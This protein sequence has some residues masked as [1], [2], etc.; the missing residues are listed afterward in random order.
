MQKI[1]YFKLCSLGREGKK[2]YKIKCNLNN[3]RYV[4]TLI[5]FVAI[6][7]WLWTLIFQYG[8]S[9]CKGTDRDSGE[10]IESL[11]WKIHHS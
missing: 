6:I 9:I 11:F 7:L 8:F 1:L 10:R 5:Q 4:Y 3:L 2:I